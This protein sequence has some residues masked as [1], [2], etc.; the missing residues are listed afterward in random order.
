MMIIQ[1]RGLEWQTDFRHLFSTSYIKE[2]EVNLIQSN[3]KIIA[4]AF[5]SPDEQIDDSWKTE[6]VGCNT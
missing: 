1:N 2:I 4:W 6:S 5:L 3:V